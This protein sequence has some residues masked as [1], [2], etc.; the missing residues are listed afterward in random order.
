M[1][2]CSTCKKLKLFSDFSLCSKSKSGYQSVCKS[3]KVV[4]VR[5]SPSRDKKHIITDKERQRRLAYYH[6]TK[7]ARNISRRMRQSLKGERKSNT[8]TELVDY[9]LAD[10]KNHLEK[11]FLPNMSWENYGEWHIDHIR[12]VSSFNIVSDTCDDF[13]ACWRLENLQPLWALD[14][15]H[16]SNKVY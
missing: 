16:K 5:N 3:C 1:K 12:P 2:N 13:K 4:S 11:L 14:N 15:I 7:V 8:W 6:K 10:L 9:S